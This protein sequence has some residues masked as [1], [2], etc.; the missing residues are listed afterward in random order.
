MNNKKSS[1]DNRSD[2]LLI[3]EQPLKNDNKISNKCNQ[4]KKEI[5]FLRTNLVEYFNKIVYWKKFLKGNKLSIP[6][7]QTFSLK[8][9][10]GSYDDLV[11]CLKEKIKLKRSLPKLE[12]NEKLNS[13]AIY[14]LSE[15]QNNYGNPLCSK[16]LSDKNEF[17]KRLEKYIIPKGSIG[18]SIILDETDAELILL[19]LLLEKADRELILNI[20]IKY[21]GIATGILTTTTKSNITII[22]FCEDFIIENKNTILK[23]NN[24]DKPSNIG[25]TDKKSFKCIN[26]I[27]CKINNDDENHK[28]KINKIDKISDITDKSCKNSI[29][30]VHPDMHS[31]LNRY[32]NKSFD[33]KQNKIHIIEKKNGILNDSEIPKDKII[34]NESLA[35]NQNQ[36][37]K[38]TKF[39]PELKDSYT[40]NI[41]NK[42]NDLNKS[43]RI[44]INESLKL[45]QSQFNTQ[46]EY[47]N[48]HNYPNFRGYSNTQREYSHFRSNST[49]INT[50]REN[51]IME[52]NSQRNLNISLE[53]ISNAP[54]LLKK[55][56]NIFPNLKKLIFKDNSNSPKNI[57]LK[58][59]KDFILPNIK[60]SNMSN[61]LNIPR[62]QRNC[63]KSSDVE[64]SA[65]SKQYDLMNSNTIEIT[66]E[67]KLNE[68]NQKTLKSTGMSFQTMQNN[69]K[70]YYLTSESNCDHLEDNIVSDKYSIKTKIMKEIEKNKANMNYSEK[71]SNDN[72]IF[73]LE[74]NNDVIITLS[75]IDG[76]KCAK[77]KRSE[78]KNDLIIV[79]NKIDETSSDLKTQFLVSKNSKLIEI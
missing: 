72:M 18:E 47:S 39:Y 63:I 1:L 74:K 71:T 54:K 76:N 59:L 67:Y 30:K 37:I 45:S 65:Q 68:I 21:F 34:L 42:S 10:V 44:N 77:S 12:L 58:N 75:S 6:K 33:L 57:Q 9:G 22:D 61:D 38:S 23:E 2:F 27:S 78:S 48:S 25:I 64:F 19:K 53:N 32:I 15:L 40:S 50:H 31:N 14:F 13:N 29:S 36:S 73:E 56:E 20:N 35:P 70:D 24:I 7:K 66:N 16:L 60:L 79:P 43:K 28:I 51:S 17:L 46:R 4:L 11:V 8:N 52:K 3:M 26:L 55:V 5:D 41:S 49:V 69:Y 62:Y